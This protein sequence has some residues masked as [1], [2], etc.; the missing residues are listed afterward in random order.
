MSLQPGRRGVEVSAIRLRASGRGDDVADITSCRLYRDLDGDGVLDGWDVLLASAPGFPSDDGILEFSGLDL[1]LAPALPEDWLLVYSI[2]PGATPA[3]DLCVTLDGKAD[4]DAS[5]GKRS[6]RVSVAP[7]IGGCVTIILGSLGIDLG[8]NNPGART[9][10]PVATDVAM[11]QIRLEAGPEE[12]LLGDAITLTASGTGDDGMGIAGAT[13]YVDSNGDGAVDPS[14][15]AL[16]GPETCTGDDGKVTFSGLGR[17]IPAAGVET[18]LVAYDFASGPPR[19]S[20]FAAGV[21]AGADVTALGAIS[22]RPVPVSGAPLT[23]EAVRLWWDTVLLDATFIDHGVEGILDEFDEII[24]NFS[25]RITFQGIGD[26]EYIFDLAPWGSFSWGW[27]D[28]GPGSTEVTIRFG[29]GPLLQPNGVYGVDPESTGL[30]LRAGQTSLVDPNGAPVQPLAT[31]VDLRG[32][33]NPRITEVVFSEPSPDGQ[34]DGGDLLEITFCVRV[35]LSTADPAQ[36]FV[37]P[38]TGDSLGAGVQFLGGGTPTNVRTVTVVLGTGPDL[39]ISGTFDPTRTNPGDPSGI[40][41]SPVAGR[42]VDAAYPGVTAL[43][44]SPDPGVDVTL[45]P[46][47]TSSGEDQ[48]EARF[49]TS[50]A[51]AGDVNGDGFADVVIGAPSAH[52]GNPYSGRAYLFLGGAVGLSSAPD[53]TSVGDDQAYSEYGATVASAGDIDGDGF[54]DIVVGSPYFGAE[55]AGK[56][57]LYRG[58][59]AGPS[60]APDWTSAGD[61]RSEA[62]FGYSVA[63]AGDVDG[64]GFGDVIVGAPGRAYG[65]QTGKAF[66]FAGGGTGLSASPLW[67]ST[68][69]D[70]PDCAFGRS[71][72]GAGD[73]DGDSYG[74]VIVG[75]SRYDTANTRAGKAFLF[76]GGPGGPSLVADWAS[77]GEDIT[78]GEYGASVGGAGDVDGDTFDD[79]IVGS[80]GSGAGGVVYGHAGGPAGPDPTPTWPMVG[81]VASYADL[82]RSVA[83]A[84][85]VNGDGYADVIAGAPYHSA[86]TL[87][88]AGRAYIFIGGPSGPDRYA[89]WRSS[90]E[91]RMSAQFGRSVSSAGDVNGGGREAVIV[92]APNFDSGG[93]DT[94][95]A[96]V[97]LLDL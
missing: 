38:V 60:T 13:L 76:R 96:Y 75:A 92:G 41:V 86:G 42:V 25:D 12:N 77:S 37:L 26:P 4:I 80:P 1:E 21:A 20:T 82:G 87:W 30:N 27:A 88:D 48:A 68:G 32:S 18:W 24:V 64:D 72:G 81:D 50:V 78:Y 61:D 5:A 43:P 40:D 9:I 94:G 83:G 91:V 7:G 15:V 36:A 8:P 95:K 11:I 33:L 45:L 2:A 6:A 97:Y 84:G 70:Q 55:D 29:P 74:D 53:W 3:D 10:G 52:G 22:G 16:A 90:G 28:P 39:A 85:D 46:I 35:S 63:A 89:F 62:N 73:V 57:Y 79:I 17:T 56:A 66:V 58:G 67:T 65:N 59:P 31:P 49:G 34:V 47:W 69:D 14:D 71:V 51:S 54:G 44:G 23:G 93:I 19:D